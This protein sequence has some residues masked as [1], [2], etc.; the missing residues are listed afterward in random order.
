MKTYFADQ[1]CE[2]K[3]VVVDASGKVLGRLASQVAKILRGKNKPTFTPHADAGDYVIITNA[4]QIKVTG[5]KR[6]DKIYYHHSGYPGGIKEINFA[7]LQAK[8]PT[9]ALKFAIRGMLPKNPLGRTLLKQKL[10]IY[11]GSEHPHSA[12]NPETI[13]LDQEKA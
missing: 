8:D 13:C 12:Q 3:W 10:K 5:K 1:N 2:K 6:Q 9:R 11:A 7:K 4:D